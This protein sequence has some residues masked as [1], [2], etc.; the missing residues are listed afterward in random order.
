LFLQKLDHC[1]H[2]LVLEPVENPLVFTAP[3]DDTGQR[4]HLEVLGNAGGL[5]FGHNLSDF[6]HAE[7]SARQQA[8][9]AEPALIR[10]EMEQ[11]NDVSA[12]RFVLSK[13]IS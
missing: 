10:E 5:T 13:G 11:A 2:T 6:V 3:F 4:E 7:F 8:G 1:P 9:N 12:D